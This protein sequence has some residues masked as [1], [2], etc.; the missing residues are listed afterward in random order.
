MHFDRTNQW[1]LEQIG[2]PP[3]IGKDGIEMSRNQNKKNASPLNYATP[4][5]NELVSELKSLCTTSA[6]I[7]VAEVEFGEYEF[8]LARNHDGT[9]SAVCTPLQEY[10]LW[11]ELLYQIETE[12][13][14]LLLVTA[15][16]A[17][18]H[19]ATGKQIKKRYAY[20]TGIKNDRVVFERSTPENARK[21]FEKKYES[22]LEADVNYP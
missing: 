10:R 22:K 7:D 14:P 13:S 8:D 15:L 17:G 16:Q 12:L 20:T 5:F 18:I 4:G 1:I 6:H 2:Q 9:V 21:M 3:E 19:P 11:E